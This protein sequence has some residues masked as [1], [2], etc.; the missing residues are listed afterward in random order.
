MLGFN[1]STLD[2]Q[3]FILTT[4]PTLHPQDYFYRDVEHIWILRNILIDLLYLN[5]SF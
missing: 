5:F 3:L 2:K 4:K 1:P